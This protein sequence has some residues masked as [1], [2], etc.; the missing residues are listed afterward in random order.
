ML[1][2]GE[3]ITALPAPPRT[4]RGLGRAFQLTNLFPNLT[5]QENVRLA[6]QARARRGGLE[7]AGRVWL[8]RTRP[9]RRGATQL[10][11]ARAPGRQARRARR[12]A[13][14]TATSASSRWRILMALEPKVFMFDEPTA[15]MSVDEVPVILDLIRAAQGASAT[16]PSC[17]SSTRWTWCASSPTASSCCTTA[18]LVADGEPAAVIAS[19]V[20]QQ[21]YLGIARGGAGMS[22]PLLELHGVH[23]HIGAYHILHGVDLEVPARP[24]DDAARP[25]RRRQDDHAA[26]HHGPVGGVAGRDRAS[27]ASDIDGAGARPTSRSSAS[28]TC[29]RAWASSPT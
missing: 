5:V 28:P 26:H 15:G 16:R 25:Q 22:A 14:R 10:L 24:G 3:D 17:W 23:T 27:T 18:Q 6:V 13:C 19:P 9:D 8:D 29:R 11:D 2:D 7:P 1:L 12:P 21:A 20:V 4:R